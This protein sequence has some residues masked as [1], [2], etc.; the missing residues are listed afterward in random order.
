MCR[1]HKLFFCFIE[2]FLY[3]ELMS[4]FFFFS[5]MLDDESVSEVPKHPHVTKSVRVLL[6]RCDAEDTRPT[7]SQKKPRAGTAFILAFINAGAQ[8]PLDRLTDLLSF[9][10]QKKKTNKAPQKSVDSDESSE[11]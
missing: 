7:A 4:K 11:E 6:K 2:D 1:D 8:F 3:A 10:A 9:T 5:M